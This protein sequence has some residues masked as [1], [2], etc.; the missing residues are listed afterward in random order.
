MDHILPLPAS[1]STKALKAARTDVQPIGEGFTLPGGLGLLRASQSP[2]TPSP[3]Y[4]PYL[5]VEATNPEIAAQLVWPRLA[6][7]VDHPSSRTRPSSTSESDPHAGTMP[8][9]AARS[10]TSCAPGERGRGRGGG[11]GERGP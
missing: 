1:T 7:K 3:K 9:H 2:E 8:E 5:V 6:A 11:R 4:P 10:G